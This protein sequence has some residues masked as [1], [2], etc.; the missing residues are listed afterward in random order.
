MAEAPS[1]MTRL[2]VSGPL[3]DGVNTTVMVQDE[4]AAMLWPHV[5]LAT[6]S[7]FAAA[8][9]PFEMTAPLNAIGRIELLVSVTVWGAEGLPTR[10]LPNVRLDGETVRLASNVNSATKASEEPLSVDWNAFGVTGK[11]VADAVSPATTA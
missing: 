8:G 5:V 9:A 11:P 2:A 6:K 4:F 7:E 10:E 3:T 1:V